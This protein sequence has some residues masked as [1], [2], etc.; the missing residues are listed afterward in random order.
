[1]VLPLD[2]L[3]AVVKDAQ[4]LAR[5]GDDDLVALINSLGKKLGVIDGVYGHRKSSRNSGYYVA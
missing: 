5:A 1:V 4:D 2:S 3:D